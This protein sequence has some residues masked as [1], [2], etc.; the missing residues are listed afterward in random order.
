MGTPVDVVV[1]AFAIPPQ[2]DMRALAQPLELCPSG[3]RIVDVPYHAYMRPEDQGMAAGAFARTAD[4]LRRPNGSILE[5]LFA[6]QLVG[7][8]PKTVTVIG[9]SAGGV[10]VERLLKSPD[11]AWIDTVIVLDGCALDLDYNGRPWDVELDPWVSFA[12][13]AAQDERLMVLAHTHIA[14]LSRR[15]SATKASSEFILRAVEDRA[16][17]PRECSIPIDWEALTA[18]PPPPA[19]TITA[20]PSGSR[21][22]KTWERSPLDAVDF[23]GNFWTLDYGGTGPADHVYV[24]WY[25]QRDIWKC[26]IAPRLHAQVGC[27]SQLSGL[28]AGLGGCVE[29]KVFIPAGIFPTS[30]LLPQL[31]GTLGGLSIG[32]GLGYMLGRKLGA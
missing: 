12:A 14:P 29:N 3:T 32:A 4:A 6:R 31:L 20:G 25:G 26:W 10:F 5:G 27:R 22:T 15:V 30:G 16:P 19:V 11:A 7:F 9:F 23:Y 13:K 21:Q 17:R 24:S 28:G 2:S 18:G 8:E 1:T